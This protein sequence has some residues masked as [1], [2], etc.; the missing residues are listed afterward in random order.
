MGLRPLEFYGIDSAAQLNSMLH[1]AMHQ[2]AG[3]AT[4]L[5]RELE[6]TGL[7]IHKPV[8]MAFAPLRGCRA[9]E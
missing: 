6:K 3:V 2:M 4:L 8:P 9:K 1:G 5:S 7:R